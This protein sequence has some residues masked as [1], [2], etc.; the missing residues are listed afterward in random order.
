MSARSRGVSSDVGM[1]IGM[2][3]SR[4]CRDVSKD[5]CKKQGCVLALCTGTVH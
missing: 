5:V 1:E 4:R 3:V 2:D